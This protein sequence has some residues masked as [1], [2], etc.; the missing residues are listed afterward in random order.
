[1]SITCNKE[2]F[3]TIPIAPSNEDEYLSIKEFMA[4]HINPDI[5]KQNDY[6]NSCSFNYD[7]NTLYMSM[8]NMIWIIR[9][10]NEYS[11]LYFKDKGI[12]SIYYDN[13]IKRLIINFGGTNTEL[14]KGFISTLSDE[15][16]KERKIDMPN[17]SLNNHEFEK[18]NGQRK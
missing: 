17:V 7:E 9:N 18:I 10:G 13:D 3:F 5:A 16:I 8:Y 2:T 14:F 12:T 11:Y 6:I 15:E 1:M 4:Q